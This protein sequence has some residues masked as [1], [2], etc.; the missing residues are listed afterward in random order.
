MSDSRPRLRPHGPALVATI[1]VVEDE[2]DI[3]RMMT[4][5]LEEAGYGVMSAPS[6]ERAMDALRTAHIDLAIIDRD[7]PDGQGVD[8]TE[9]IRAGSSSRRLPIVTMTASP[10][11]LRDAKQA[12]ESGVQEFLFKPFMAETLLRNVGRLLTAPHK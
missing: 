2:S 7:L 4:R 11:R 6:Q 9:Q 10:V 1:L 8:L 3:V 12:T 5:I